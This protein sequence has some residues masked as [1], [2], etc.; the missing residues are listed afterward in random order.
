MSKVNYPGLR[1]HPHHA[2]AQKLF[3]GCGGVLSFEMKGGASAAEML[4]DQVTLAMQAPSLGGIET[5][6]SI[7]AA[8]SHVGM[9]REERLKSGITDGLIRL[10]VGIEDVT[11]LIQDFDTVLE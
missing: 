4:I 7:P 3:K 2:R 8:C 11:D 9:S 10:A 6:I 5:L 1:S